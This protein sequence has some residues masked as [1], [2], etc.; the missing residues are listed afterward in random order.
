MS[1]LNTRD[2]FLG[3]ARISIDHGCLGLSAVRGTPPK[4]FATTIL[5]VSHSAQA[6]ND[7][8]VVR[9]ELI[10]FPDFPD[11]VKGTLRWENPSAPQGACLTIC[12]MLRP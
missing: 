9:S 11:E 7:S 6:F 2:N 5:P 4:G 8:E 3:S 12:L 1:F 10:G